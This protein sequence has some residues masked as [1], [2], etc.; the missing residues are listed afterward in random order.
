MRLVSREPSGRRHR[1]RSRPEKNIYIYIYQFN[2]IQ[3]D[4]T[5]KM[6]N[7]FLRAQKINEI[8]VYFVKTFGMQ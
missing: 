3:H 2:R 5:I 4:S 8:E 6:F 1:S 7:L